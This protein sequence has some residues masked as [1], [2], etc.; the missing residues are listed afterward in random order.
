MMAN[1]KVVDNEDTA[2]EAV[3][4]VPVGGRNVT[5]CGWKA[6]ALG[7]GGVVGELQQPD[8][9]DGRHAVESQ[10]RAVVHEL[11]VA[12]GHDAH[13]NDHNHHHQ[14]TGAKPYQPWRSRALHA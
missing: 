3:P 9:R 7:H 1:T 14:V 2:A 4:P 8:R 13:A 5:G 11:R 12:G 10:A 6:V